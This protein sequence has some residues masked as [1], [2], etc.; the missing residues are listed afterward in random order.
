VPLSYCPLQTGSYSH[1]IAGVLDFIHRPD[2]NSYK[3]KEEQT[4][5]LSEDFLK[6]TFHSGEDTLLVGITHR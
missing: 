4:L 2:F 5:F 1:R 6:R 3:K